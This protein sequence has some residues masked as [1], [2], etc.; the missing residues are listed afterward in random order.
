[1]YNYAM[2]TLVVIWISYARVPFIAGYCFSI[3]KVE[4]RELRLFDSAA[5]SRMVVKHMGGLTVV[6]VGPQ[7]GD[8]IEARGTPVMLYTSTSIEIP[9]CTVYASL[10]ARGSQ[11]AG[12]SSR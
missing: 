4:S 12:R 9:A 3:S 5:F 7:S 11:V 6:D 1:M 2:D 10:H 8:Y